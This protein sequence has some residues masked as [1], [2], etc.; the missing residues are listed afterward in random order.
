MGKGKNKS[1]LTQSI[2]VNTL[3][4]GA[5]LETMQDRHENESG[6]SGASMST[7][8]LGQRMVARQSQASNNRLMRV[9]NVLLLVLVLWGGTQAYVSLSP[10]QRHAIDTY[11][12]T[13]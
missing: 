6:V 4:Q 12:E 3:S 2:D 8:K 9:V 11:I 1:N 7:E 10:E 13:N 5:R